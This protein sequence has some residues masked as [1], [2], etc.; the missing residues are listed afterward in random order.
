MKK[1]IRIAAAATVLVLLCVSFSACAASR[2]KGEWVDD[3]S[4]VMVKFGDGGKGEFCYHLGE[5]WIDAVEFTYK[6]SGNKLTMSYE[7]MTD[8][9]TLKFAKNS[10]VVTDSDG[11]IWATLYRYTGD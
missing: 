1:A 8:R 7:G 6:V 11:E 10:V 9:F 3:T 5:Q 2:L 4:S